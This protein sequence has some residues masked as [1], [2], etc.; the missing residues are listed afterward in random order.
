MTNANTT[1]R[2]N[3][4]ALI[5]SCLLCL[6]AACDTPPEPTST[7]SDGLA[8]GVADGGYDFRRCADAGVL[9]YCPGMGAELCRLEVIRGAFAGGCAADADCVKADVATNCLGYGLCEPKPSVL[10]SRKADF[11]AAATAELSPWCG[12]SSCG[13]SGGSCVDLQTQPACVDGAC[14]T[15]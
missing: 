13:T 6:G 11:E 1:T 4:V 9:A 2:S 12:A 7:L 5:A 14:T 15:R 8:Q 3:A 10:A